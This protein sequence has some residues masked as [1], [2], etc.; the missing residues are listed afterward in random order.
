MPLHEPGCSGAPRGSDRRCAPE[1]NGSSTPRGSRQERQ[2]SPAAPQRNSATNP[3]N[4]GRTAGVERYSRRR[5]LPREGPVRHRG[6]ACRECGECGNPE[7]S[8]PALDCVCGQRWCVSG[9]ATVQQSSVSQLR[10]SVIQAKDSSPMGSYVACENI[11]NACQEY[12]ELSGLATAKL[13]R[14]GK[15]FD[16]AHPPARGTAR[17]YWRFTRGAC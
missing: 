6:S 11:V 4:V 7:M 13:G 10:L 8:G 3:A 5:R 9:V 16:L 17:I 15:I 2:G 12:E 14:K 1:R